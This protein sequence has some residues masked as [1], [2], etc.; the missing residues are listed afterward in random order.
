M[1]PPSCKNQGNRKKG[2]S[3]GWFQMNILQ[4]AKTAFK[5]AALCIIVPLFVIFIGAINLLLD[6]FEDGVSEPQ[7]QQ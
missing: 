4:T 6:F 2:V 1:A 3:P 7:R 5:I